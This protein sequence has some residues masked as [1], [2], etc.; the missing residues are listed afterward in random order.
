MDQRELQCIVRQLWVATLGL[1]LNFSALA[2]FIVV[3]PRFI[4]AP[5]VALAAAYLADSAYPEGRL[6]RWL[7]YGASAASVVGAC[8]AP[9]MG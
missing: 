6:Y 8:A 2:I 5:L 9:Y 4:P 1:A 7:C 3:E